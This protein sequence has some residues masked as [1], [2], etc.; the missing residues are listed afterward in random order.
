[1]AGVPVAEE[2]VV[3]VGTEPALGALLLPVDAGGVNEGTEH[4]RSWQP[5]F[6]EEKMESGCPCCPCLHALLAVTK[7]V[8]HLLGLKQASEHGPA[9]PQPP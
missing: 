1:M 2:V 6:G 4:G 3:V 7:S 8:Q 9:F 5:G